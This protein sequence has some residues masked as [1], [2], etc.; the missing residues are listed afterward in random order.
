MSALLCSH[1]RAVNATRAELPV[2]A[3]LQKQNHSFTAMPR[4]H[5]TNA[6]IVGDTLGNLDHS[7]QTGSCSELSGGTHRGVDG[8]ITWQTAGQ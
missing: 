3:P 1:I 8:I 6:N 5:V 4:V 7:Q 2:P